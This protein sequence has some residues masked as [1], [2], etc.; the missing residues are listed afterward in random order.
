MFLALLIQ[1]AKRMRRIALSSASF[2]A[3]PYFSKVSHKLHNFSKEILNIKYVMSFPTSTSEKFLSLRRNQRYFIINMHRSSCKIPII[4]IGLYK[5]W[6]F[7]AGFRRKSNFRFH[8]SPSSGEPSCSLR[9]NRQTDGQVDRHR[10][11]DRHDEA[12]SRC[13]QVRTH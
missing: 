8:Q 10:Q 9:T 7:S 5:T 13:S 2:P 12:N 6:F 1:N 11:T 3:L 4:L